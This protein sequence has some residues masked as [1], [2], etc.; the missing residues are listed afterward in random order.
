M[1]K[2]LGRL[3]VFFEKPF[4]VGVFERKEKHRGR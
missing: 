3:T 4:W 2:V 1:D